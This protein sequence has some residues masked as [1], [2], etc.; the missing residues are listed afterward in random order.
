MK[1]GPGEIYF[2]N[3]PATFIA[4]EWSNLFLNVNRDVVCS[5]KRKV[6]RVFFEIDNKTDKSFEDGLLKIFIKSNKLCIN[7]FFVVDKIEKNSS[8]CVYLD[9]PLNRYFNCFV[10]SLVF[11]KNTP[12]KELNIIL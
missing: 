5:N 8:Y 12:I 11:E 7:K 3:D 2:T 9:I 10:N 6:T 1:D 4:N